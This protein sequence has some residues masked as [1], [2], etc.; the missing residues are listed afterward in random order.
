VIYKKMGNNKK[1]LEYYRKSI[2]KNRSYSDSYLNMSAIYIEEGQL[3]KAIE[4]LT[5]GIRYSPDA[6]YLYY[7]RACCYA[8][9]NRK[10]EAM[11]DLEKALD[12]CP[13]IVNMVK[14]DPDFDSLRQDDRFNRLLS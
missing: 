14:V 7:N 6:K 10:E 3:E 2:E 13:N 11:N 9:L 4:I 5:E 8:R 1:A 12:L